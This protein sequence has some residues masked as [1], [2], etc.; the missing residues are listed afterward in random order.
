MKIYLGGKYKIENVS[1]NYQR[2][3]RCWGFGI[4]RLQ[5]AIYWTVKE[6]DDEKA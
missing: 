4:G 3:M 1:L 6:A 2:I 5:V